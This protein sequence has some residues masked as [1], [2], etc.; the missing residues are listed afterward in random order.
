MHLPTIGEFL[1]AAGVISVAF[2]LPVAILGV[3]LSRLKDF[4]TSFTKGR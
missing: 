3:V 1:V 2:G 4:W